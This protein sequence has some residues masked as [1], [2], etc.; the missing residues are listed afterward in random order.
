M[1]ARRRLAAIVFTDLVNYT[2]LTQRDEPRM[3]RLLAE[4][5]AIVRPI[6]ARFGGREVKTL[7][8]GFLLVFDSALSATQCAVE[9][10]RQSAEW[11][12][13]SMEERPQVRI[14]VHVGDLI[15]EDN[16]IL[17]DAVNVASRLESCA[18]P[19]GICVSGPVYEQVRGKVPQAFEKLPT[20]RLR[21]VE[22]P[23]EAYR[24]VG[25][26]GPSEPAARKSP[27]G[28]IA[29]IPFSSISPD[30]RDEYLADGLTE[31]VITA[32]S[33]LGG[34]RVIAR[35]SVDVY[36]S[37]PKSVSQ[38]GSELNLR[39]LLEGSVRRAGNRVRVT[40]QLIDVATQE[41]LWSRNY[42]RDLDD[43]FAIQTDIA[44]EVA[45][46][47]QVT[48][49]EQEDRRL[50]SRPTGIT[51]SYL[52]YLKGRTLVKSTAPSSLAEARAQ[53]ERAVQLDPKNARAYSGLADA[54]YRGA[55]MSGRSLRFSEE[56]LR[57]ARGLVSQ[58]LLLDPTVAEAHASLGQFLDEL[59]E[60]AGADKEF[61][62]AISLNPSYASAHQWY[63]RLLTDKGQ[64]EYA[65]EELHLAEEADPLS[66]GIKAGLARLL[67][68]LGRAREAASC[69]RRLSE[70]E[71]EGIRYH[72]T[73]FELAQRSMDRSTLLEE[74]TWVTQRS[75]LA[76]IEPACTFWNG[77]YA[78][79]V[80]DTQAARQSVERLSSARDH[81][82]GAPSDW[83]PSFIA[84]IYA[85]LK[86]ADGSFAWAERAFQNRTLDFGQWWVSPSYD[87]L[88]ADPRFR[89]LTKR[90]N[91]A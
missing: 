68:A 15:D 76:G 57:E 75:H 83:A 87:N 28:R 81:D 45:Q 29:V 36:K 30:S 72:I 50:R 32:L 74:V 44:R 91:L 10:Q 82:T 42:D 39:S 49:L 52:A 69:A 34:L 12:T 18:E 47:L 59:Y 77:K 79:I 21:G 25:P 84:E 35:S 90:A 33:Q 58:S 70:L 1:A 16:D 51:D 55:W 37:H 89:G 11:V 48:V 65:L 80:G 54:V 53:F 9:I 3:L 27:P 62:T 56:S 38:I 85:Q 43:V 17:G 7:G 5:R 6:L 23:I 26:S 31:E 61:R 8:D 71:P 46:S 22:V 63:A 4:H 64:L 66:P 60:F 40:A 14:A 86:D 41:H 19:G 78:A 2:S 73:R 67:A 24:V 20:P 13:E 88:R